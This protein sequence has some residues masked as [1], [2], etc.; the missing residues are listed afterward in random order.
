VYDMDLSF[1]GMFLYFRDA[2]TALHYMT[3]NWYDGD[4]DYAFNE[5]ITG[6]ERLAIAVKEHIALYEISQE[7]KKSEQLCELFLNCG[8]ARFFERIESLGEANALRTMIAAFLQESGHR[9][10]SDRDFYFP[11][12]ADDL[13]IL[14]R[15]I[16]AHNKSDEDPRVR[17]R[18]N[19][20]KRENVI[21]NIE[22]NLRKKPFSQL[23]IEAFRWTLTYILRCLEY[24]DDERHF[25][26]R[27]T[28]SL[29]KAFL[30]VGRRIVMRGE[31][32]A[33]D[34]IWFLSKDELYQVLD[35]HYNRTLIQ[36]KIAGR[37]H[38]F[39]AYDRKDYAPPKFLFQGKA[40]HF[41]ER[42]TV[43]VQGKNVLKGMPTSRGEYTGTA[44]VVKKL[45]DIGRVNAQ[46]ILVANSTDPGWTPVFAVI[47]AVVVET[48]GLLSHSSCLAR[49]YGFPAAQVE[50]AM[51]LIPDG[52]TITV[53]GDTG[54][55]YIH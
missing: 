4:N 13:N 34:D 8:D 32:E 17:E 2:M 31:L 5:L 50:G 40:L 20:L 51:S 27:N 25:I 9:G 43:L 54:E 11:R 28:Y 18:E 6:T 10:H 15:A 42:N 26:D 35:G 23:K 39:E 44:R 49:E 55:V 46:E 41:E 24:R 48:G 37:R 38:N 14:Y 16:E 36:Q 3:K 19:N 22:E 45:S 21:V 1:P 53:N 52:A 12:Y 29:R 47:S 33:I 30:E 7:I